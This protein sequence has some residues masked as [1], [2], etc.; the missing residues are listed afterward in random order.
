[1][2]GIKACKEHNHWIFDIASAILGK[3]RSEGVDVRIWDGLCIWYWE[4]RLIIMGQGLSISYP[5]KLYL[6]FLLF[7]ITTKTVNETWQF[8]LSSLLGRVNLVGLVF[9]L[10]PVGAMS[11]CRT[12][13]GKL[14]SNYLWIEDVCFFSSSNE[15]CLPHVLPT[16]ASRLTSTL[17]LS[18]QC[19]AY[20]GWFVNVWPGDK[21][22]KTRLRKA[23][24]YHVR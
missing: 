23:W 10:F 22:P 18:I 4:R 17:C 7:C 19:S 14:I 24:L 8:G 6:F 3:H 9:H 11:Y 20:Q 2:S 13:I 16:V 21:L 5:Y 1:M 15:A 12:I